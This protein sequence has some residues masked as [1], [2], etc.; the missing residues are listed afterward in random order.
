[1]WTA[2]TNV[3]HRGSTSILSRIHEQLS[4]KVARSNRLLC[5]ASM[6]D[7][8]TIFAQHC[9]LLDTLS[10]DSTYSN[11]CKGNLDKGMLLVGV[12]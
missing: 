3:I 7:Q 1:M 2:A 6:A 4:P 10:T 11:L 12:F 8:A 9:M 5:A